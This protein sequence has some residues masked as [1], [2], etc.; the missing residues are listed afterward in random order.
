MVKDDPPMLTQD[1]DNHFSLEFVLFVNSCLTKDY[2]NR[3]KY[4]KLT[5]MSFYL[6]QVL[7]ISRLFVD[8]GTKVAVF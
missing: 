8:L 2:K 1:D 4:D 6:T 3:P 7:F 5:K